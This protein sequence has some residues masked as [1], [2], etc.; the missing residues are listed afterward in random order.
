MPVLDPADLA[1][2]PTVAVPAGNALQAK[3]AYAGLWLR[4]MATIL[5]TALIV[6]LFFI[7]DWPGEMPGSRPWRATS[8]GRDS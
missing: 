1:A 3:A 5:D 4:V 7:T 2:I 6:V 8:Y